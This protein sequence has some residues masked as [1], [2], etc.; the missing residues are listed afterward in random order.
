MINTVEAQ[1]VEARIGGAI[2]KI[3]NAFKEVS[4]IISAKTQTINSMEKAIS[5]S[6]RNAELTADEIVYL[7]KQLVIGGSTLD[8]VLSA[9]ARLYQAEANEINFFADKLKAELTISAALGIL[10]DS[11]GL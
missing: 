4:E 3:E 11:V 9:E 10:S 5:L 2:S 1:Q 6:K 7:R 8:N